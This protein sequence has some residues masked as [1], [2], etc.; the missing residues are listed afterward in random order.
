MTV[1]FNAWALLPSF[2]VA[3]DGGAP[4]ATD[5]VAANQS[6]FLDVDWVKVT[7]VAPVSVSVTEVSGVTAPDGKTVPNL[8]VVKG[9]VSDP[10]QTATAVDVVITRARDGYKWRG[11]GT[12]A[13]VDPSQTYGTSTDYPATAPTWT[14]NGTMP[15]GS[16][17]ESGSYSIYADVLANGVYTSSAP[18]TVNV[19]SNAVPVS[20]SFGPSGITTY[21]GQPRDTNAV[22]S[23]A[24]GYTDIALCVLELRV[25]SVSTQA[26]YDA[27]QN[28][29]FLLGDNGQRIGGVTPGPG[30]PAISNSLLSLNCADTVIFASTSATNK[31]LQVRWNL[32]PQS[33]LIGTNTISMDVTDRA[34]AHAGLVNRA[35]WTVA[36]PN[37]APVSISFSSP[38]G[39]SRV[40]YGYS[41]SAAYSDADGIRDLKNL[42]LAIEQASVEAQVYYSQNLN[43]LYILNDSKNAW[44]GGVPPGP[45]APT[46]SNSLL[47]VDC[48][49]TTIFTSEARNEVQVRWV[50]RPK[51]GLIG[52]N[53]ILMV[54]FDNHGVSSGASF[55]TTWTVYGTSSAMMA[56]SSGSSGTSPSATSTDQTST[57]SAQPSAQPRYTNENPFVGEMPYNGRPNNDPLTTQGD[58]TQGPPIG[59]LSSSSNSTTASAATQSAPETA[60]TPSGNAS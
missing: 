59:D 42:V 10:A 47:T 16:N 8:S 41:T 19:V 12:P 54:A 29:L 11:S 35:T 4:A 3:Y 2:N 43:R 32:T 23:D 22:Y 28:K 58:G 48:A 40:D 56:P 25:G 49:Q 24:D 38:N 31:Q 44:L 45:G 14:T 5:N 27:V 1:R 7:E 18:V 51:A 13:W 36:R 37:S 33:G 46:I 34:G 52:T 53:N 17:L 26:F 20:E 9:Q 21:T 39:S 57:A 30:A 55:K 60:P 6:Y 15:S 50:L